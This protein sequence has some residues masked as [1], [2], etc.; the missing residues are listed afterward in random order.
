MAF[1]LSPE[2]SAGIAYVV[3]DLAVAAIW[4]VLLFV[5]NTPQTGRVD[6]GFL[7]YALFELPERW[8]YW[9]LIALPVACLVLAAAYFTAVARRKVGSVTLCAAGLVLAAA[10][11]FTLDWTIALFATLPLL[12]TIPAAKC[13]LTTRSCGP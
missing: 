7:Y 11:W 2:T 8:F 3:P 1:K 4:G 10:T 5:G 13:H 12:F 9:W 6:T